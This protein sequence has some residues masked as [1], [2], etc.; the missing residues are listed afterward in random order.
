MSAIAAT[1]TTAIYINTNIQF[2]IFHSIFLFFTVFLTSA[3]GFVLN[4]F[5]DLEKDK[6][7]HV[8]R[9]LPRGLIRPNTAYY[10][11]LLL[12]I[13]S[14]LNSI[15]VSFPVFL[16]NMLTLFF[17]SIYSFINNR[18]GV[19][20]N[21]ITGLNCSF[22]FIIGML[23]G[24]FTLLISFVSFLA[25]LLIIGREIILDIRDIESDKLIEKSSFPIIYG[26]NKSRIIAGFFF[27]FCTIFSVAIGVAIGNFW[28][29]LLVVGL[30]NLILWTTF[31]YYY[32]TP[33]DKNLHSFI[34]ATRIAFILLLPAILLT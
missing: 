28:F 15:S 33:S 22:I 16:L 20:A 8:N 3:F 23:A 32:F 1:I 24:N 18:Y 25:F 6:K 30:L 2:E 27:G 26:I 10:F 7:H 4:D 19:V 14:I 9:I 29:N 5:I 21:I 17:L 13:T 34:T 11:A 12:G 31:L